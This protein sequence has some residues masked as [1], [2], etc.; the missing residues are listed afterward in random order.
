MGTTAERLAAQGYL[1]A[2]MV[3]AIERS[4]G[5][6][7]ALTCSQNPV[8]PAR[9]DEPLVSGTAAEVLVEFHYATVTQGIGV[10]LIK[11]GQGWQVDAVSCPPSPL[12]SRTP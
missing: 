6:F 9:I 10:K 1:T 7:G 3:S 5:D 11:T 2:N 8:K 12:P 4:S